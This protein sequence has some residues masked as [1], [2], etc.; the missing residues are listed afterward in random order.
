M[1]W[2]KGK[3]LVMAPAL[4]LLCAFLPGCIQNRLSEKTV[5]SKEKQD[6]RARQRASS[7]QV[8]G[9]GSSAVLVSTQRCSF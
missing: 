3:A 6:A 5:Q 1:V 9:G 4:G 8:Q 2:Y 7:S